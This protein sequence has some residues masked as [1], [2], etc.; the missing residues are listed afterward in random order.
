MPKY[1]SVKYIKNY[2][3]NIFAYFLENESILLTRAKKTPLFGKIP[4]VSKNGHLFL[5]IFKIHEHF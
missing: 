1:F 5:S 4:Q 2:R 3:N